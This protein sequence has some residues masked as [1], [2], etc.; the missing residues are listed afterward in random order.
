ML[1]KVLWTALLVA[2]TSTQARAALWS[3]P[4][5]GGY[6]TRLTC[7]VMNVS[8]TA[9]PVTIQV[10]DGTAGKVLANTAVQLAP[11]HSVSATTTDKATGYCWIGGIA[12][13]DARITFSVVDSNSGAVLTAVQVR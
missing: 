11:G 7:R 2:A 13:K 3:A 8:S 10:A 6:G 12:R 9:K 4:L 5:S 1:R